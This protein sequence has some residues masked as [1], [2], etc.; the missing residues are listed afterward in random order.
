MAM[1]RRKIREHI[2]KLLFD[3]DFYTQEENDRQLELYFREI[4]GEEL[5]Q[6]KA[7]QTPGMDDA[8]S[9]EENSAAAPDEEVWYSLRFLNDEDTQIPEYATQEERSYISGKVL[10]ILQMLPQIDE[11][12]GSYSRGWKV[13][14]MPKADL[15][16]L[17]LAV[18]EIR[19]DEKIPDKVAVNEAVE[20]AKRYGNDDSAAFINGVLSRFVS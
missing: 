1:S 7:L 9:A 12:I 17:R 3:L 20:L 2:F 18:Y 11:A 19:Y 5:A 6:M 4:Q 13:E 14:R 8:E 10:G 15:A 16:I